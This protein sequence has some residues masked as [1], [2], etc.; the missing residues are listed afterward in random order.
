[1]YPSLFSQCEFL[2]PFLLDPA[3]GRFGREVDG[4]TQTVLDADERVYFPLH[5]FS[6]SLNVSTS[7]ALILDS[8]LAG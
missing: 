7:V 2:F 4:V 3:G 6:D 8:I 5:G 1:M